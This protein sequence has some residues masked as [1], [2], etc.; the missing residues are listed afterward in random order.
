MDGLPH[1]GHG[2]RV[3]VVD[4]HSLVADAIETVVR[5]SP[6]MQVVGSASDLP[7]AWALLEEL[8][9]DV[10]LMD[11]ELPSGDGVESARQMKVAHPKTKFLILTGQAT[12]E[13]IS[14]TVSGG[15]DGFVSKSS[16]VDVL[17]EAIRRAAAGEAVFSATDLSRVLRGLRSD[18]A[19]TALSARETEVLRYMAEGRSTGDIA[20]TLFLSVHTVRSHVRHILQKLGAHSKLEAVAMALRSGI[21][22]PPE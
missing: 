3:I 17:L 4:D 7:E 20:A 15:L 16:G 18:R 22:D 14:R 2:A 8:E 12:D 19:P 10:V 9:P 13:V 1:P 6:G 5:L 21:V 11:V